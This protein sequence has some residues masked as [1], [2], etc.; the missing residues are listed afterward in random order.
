MT[1]LRETRSSDPARG[2][3]SK[4]RGN[5]RN[6]WRLG[7]R[8]VGLA[9]L[10]VLLAV[11]LWDPPPVETLRLKTLDAYQSIAPRPISEQPVLIVDIDEK[12]LAAL[13]QWP[14][15][16]TTLAALTRRVMDAGAATIAFDIV[17]AE[18]D[19][20]SPARMAETLPTLSPA[21]KELLRAVPDNDDVFADTLRQYATVLGRFPRTRDEGGDAT[22]LKSASVS[23]LGRD[24]SPFL[25]KFDGVLA[26]LPKLESAARGIGMLIRTQERDN[27]MRRVP[28]FVRVGETVQPTLF[29]EVL[30]VATGQKTYVVK[31]FEAG[32]A[33]VVMAGNEIP[34]D[35]KGRIWVHYSRPNPSL[36][37]SAA[38][39]LSGAVPPERLAGRLVLVGTSAVGLRD[40]V[41]TPLRAAMPGVEAHAQLLESILSGSRLQRPDFA[42]GA[43]LIALFLLGMLVIYL[44]PRVGAWWTLTVGAVLS[45]GIVTAAGWF[46]VSHQMLF[47]VSYPL[48]AS[49]LVFALLAFMNY[50]REQQ[51]RRQIRTA[52]SRYLAPEIVNRLSDNPE[53]LRLGGEMREMT[54][55]FSD[56]QGFTGIA[57]N[58][59]AVGLTRLINEILTPVTAEVL[60]TGGTV[61]K[62]MGD[63][64]M[65]FWNAPLDDADHA[66]NACRAALA[67]R[68]L[69]GPL[70]DELQRQAEEEGHAFVPVNFGVG[71]N[72]GECCVGN[73]GSDMRFDYSVLGDA[74]NLA[75]R[76]E[77]QTRTYG[78]GIVIG[79]ETRSRIPDMASLELDLVTV[80]G[81]TVPARIHA[82]L[83]GPGLAK[84]AAFTALSEH[85]AELLGAYRAMDWAAAANAIKKARAAARDTGLDL[86]RLYDVFEERISAFRADPPPSEWDGVFVATTKG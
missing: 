75:A 67:I 28:A 63:A 47:D 14:W 66:A 68:E 61:D 49:L 31:T 82:L 44:V 8:G 7:I 23:W 52:F 74:V 60:K 42:V 12:S 83:G 15:P 69:I 81:K 30:R 72:T 13:G 17:F 10:L 79:D 54:L 16:R 46:F 25:S 59:D 36:Y 50:V 80:K 3:W 19:R 58:Y 76:L 57:E 78:V 62:Y 41:A 55:L 6:T 21:A 85:Q 35:G 45:A 29:L 71:V 39:V 53:N 26:N 20:L 5:R 37:V 24:P 11:R 40:F 33:S 32:V 48:L 1:S 84:D 73:M 9:F 56:V 38:D 65:A 51:D 86:D 2:G 70:N 4:L 34:T 43:E 77:G 18:P 64:L 27:I 22:G